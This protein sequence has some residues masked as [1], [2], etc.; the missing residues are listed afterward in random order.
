[1]SVVNWLKTIYKPYTVIREHG[2]IR[3]H[4]VYNYMKPACGD[5]NI[6]KIFVENCQIL[7]TVYSKVLNQS[8][9]TPLPNY[10]NKIE[11]GIFV[12]SKFKIIIYETRFILVLVDRNYCN[13][14]V[15]KY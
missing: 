3:Y 11:C 2:L 7:I 5:K 8:N 14:V 10:Q 13:S 12:Y 1:V 4:V 9:V 15:L 6:S